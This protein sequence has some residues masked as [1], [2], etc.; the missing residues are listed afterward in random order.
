MKENSFENKEEYRPKID[1]SVDKDNEIEIFMDFWKKYDISIHE[2]LDY[3]KDEKDEEKVKQEVEKFVTDKY[4]DEK[5]INE[6]L[7]TAQKNW[8]EKESLFYEKS[9]KYFGEHPWP[10]GNYNGMGSIWNIYPRYIEQK[11]FTFPL[12]K[13]KNSKLVIAH[14][15]LHFLEYDYLEKKYGLKPS[16]A[17]DK[18]NTFWQ[19]TENLNALIEQTNEWDDF[20][21]GVKKERVKSECREMYK[22]MKN[23][24]TGKNVDEMV[25]EILIKRKKEFFRD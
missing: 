12:D 8:Q 23:I 15:M 6:D 5:G 13:E 14:E 19:F 11:G 3:L 24:W 17:S 25:N 1:F 16:E 18:D 10:K 21:D 22:E 9:K 7:E 20:T 2:D 4:A